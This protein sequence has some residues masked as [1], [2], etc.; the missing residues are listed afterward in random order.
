VGE[1]PLEHF[2]NEFLDLEH[3][4][5]DN[6]LFFQFDQYEYGELTN[7][8]KLETLNMRVFIVARNGVE[9]ELHRR[10]RNYATA[11]YAMFEKSGCN[12][13]GIADA[14]II[15]AAHFY[16]AVE[17]NKNIKLCEITLSLL[18]ETI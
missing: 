14:G 2:I 3:Y 4:V 13:G 6:T 7:Q 16:D 9:K 17:A 8:S 15:T 18:K 12:L 11:F 5:Y 1:R 10:L